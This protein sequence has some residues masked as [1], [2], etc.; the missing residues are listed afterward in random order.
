MEAVHGDLASHE[1]GFPALQEVLESGTTSRLSHDPAQHV[2]AAVRSRTGRCPSRCSIRRSRRWRPAC[3]ASSPAGRTSKAS[4]RASGCRWS[5]AIC[6]TRAI[7]IVVGHYEGDTIIGAEA[8]W[9]SCCAARCRSA[10]S[11]GLYPGEFGSLA[12]ILR[13]PTAVQKALRLPSGAIVIGLGKWGELSA[14][15]LGE[16]A[17]PRRAPIRAAARRDGLGR[18]AGRRATAEKVGLS[19]L[20]IGGNS[21]TNIAVGDSVGAILRAIAQANRELADGSGSATTI[22]EVEIIE[23]YADT[24]IEAAHAVK[25]LAPLIGKEL[26]DRIDA[27]PLLQPGRDG[28]RRL[29]STSGRDAWRRWEVSVVTPRR[30]AQPA[31]LPKPL[32]DRL[33]RAVLESDNADAELLA[34]LAELAIG[35]PAEPD[36]AHREIRFLTLSD[37]ARAEATRSSDSRSSWSA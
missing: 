8:R 37:R 32:A 17:S 20:L 7:P 3:S 16:P 4:S 22:Q 27:A 28:R 11:L 35:E 6:A 12:V 29:T 1:P 19:V 13:K 15:Q 18:V 36:E 9:T 10:T 30:K 26:N 21:T 31:C 23:L 14:G 5:T 2:T 24:A 33:K 34:A 25:R